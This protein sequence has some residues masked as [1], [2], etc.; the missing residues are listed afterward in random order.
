MSLLKKSRS[1]KLQSLVMASV[2][3]FSFA[4]NVNAIGYQYPLQ[5]DRFPVANGGRYDFGGNY[6]FESIDFSR[7]FNFYIGGD[8]GG[9]ITSSKYLYY[10]PVDKTVGYS[11]GSTTF[12]AGEL[13]IVE[14]QDEPGS[15]LDPDIGTIHLGEA[16][17][18][19][20][21]G[22]SKD[23]VEDLIHNVQGDQ[24]INGSQDI[25]GDQTVDGSQ[26]VKSV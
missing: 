9:S 14:I 8:S 5:Y 3:A 26:T 6:D 13:Y 16:Q 7:E 12:K 1:R 22:I 24:N 23:E 10:T 25:T 20:S 2:L 17:S 4:G 21:G 19:L 11:G 15:G 18:I